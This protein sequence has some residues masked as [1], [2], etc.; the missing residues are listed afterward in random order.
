[1][2]LQRF[3]TKRCQAAYEGTVTS[4]VWT[5]LLTINA[6]HLVIYSIVSQPGK[7][8]LPV[9]PESIHFWLFSLTTLYDVRL[10]RLTLH[11]CLI[12]GHLG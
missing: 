6:V 9:P 10:N 12:R 3:N 4:H 7:L 5:A 11:L 8:F 2:F 1:M